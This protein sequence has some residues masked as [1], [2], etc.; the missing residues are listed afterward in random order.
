MRKCRS[1]SLTLQWGPFFS[2]NVHLAHADVYGRI[3]GRVT[4]PSGGVVPKATIVAQTR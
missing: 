2:L 4:D 1:L 3:R